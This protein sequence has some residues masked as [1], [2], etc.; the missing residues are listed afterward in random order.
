MRYRFIDA[1]KAHHQVN[2][3]CNMLAVSR[4]GYDAWSSR[5]ASKRTSEDMVLLP[6]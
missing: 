2:R 4:F 5:P 1:E 3:L 6:I